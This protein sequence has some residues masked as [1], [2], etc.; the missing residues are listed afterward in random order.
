[1]L[2]LFCIILT[3]FESIQLKSHNAFIFLFLNQYN[4]LFNNTWYYFTQFYWS[5]LY[6]ISIYAQLNYRENQWQ[7]NICCTFFVYKRSSFVSFKRFSTI[8]LQFCINGVNVSLHAKN[9]SPYICCNI[10]KQG[11]CWPLKSSVAYNVAIISIFSLL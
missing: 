10:I 8:F 9:K 6:E 5:S 3:Y 11:Y 4:I 1:M 2:Y 7:K